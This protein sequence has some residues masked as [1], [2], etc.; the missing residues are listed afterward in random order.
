M[1]LNIGSV[2]RVVRIAI[3]IALLL[4][5]VLVEEALGWFGLV[6][7]IPLLTGMFGNCPLYTA[8]RIDTRTGRARTGIDSLHVCAPSNQECSH[9]SR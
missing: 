4:M 7:F 9:E 2:D 8:L 1:G 5:S 3:G 6:G